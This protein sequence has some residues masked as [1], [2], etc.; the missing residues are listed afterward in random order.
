MTANSITEIQV[1]NTAIAQRQATHWFHVREA[2]KLSRRAFTDTLK[3]FAAYIDPDHNAS[4]SPE[5]SYMRLTQKLYSPLGLSS[6]AIHHLRETTD[7][8]NLRDLMSPRLLLAL[9]VLEA[10]LADWIDHAMKNQEL[11]SVI[12][13][14]IDQEAR[15]AALFCGVEP[16][17]KATKKRKAA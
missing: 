1:L 15:K 4:S 11:R 10:E 16:K 14:H 6:K 12:K 7:L 8:N 3:A 9:S 17:A 2:G 13:Q 5:Q